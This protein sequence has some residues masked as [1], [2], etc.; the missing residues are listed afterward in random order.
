MGIENLKSLTQLNL[1]M[2]EIR[3]IDHLPPLS[4]LQTLYLNNN[5]VRPQNT[6]VRLY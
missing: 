1:G 3:D 5:K 4:N 2:N 6:A